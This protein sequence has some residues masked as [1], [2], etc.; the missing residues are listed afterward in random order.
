M[1]MTDQVFRD[2]RAGGEDRC[3]AQLRRIREVLAEARDRDSEA[4]LEDIARILGERGRPADIYQ[5][6]LG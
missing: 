2:S 3:D 6:P 5:K 1:G 4:V